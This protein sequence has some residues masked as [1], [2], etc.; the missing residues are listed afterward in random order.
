MG[1]VADQ[2]LQRVPALGQRHHH[3]GLPVAEMDIVVVGRDR[4]VRRAGL[5]V[6]Q[7]VVMPGPR[8]VDA[9]RRDPMPRRPIRTVKRSGTLKPS[10]G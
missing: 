7:Q 2:Q 10:I 5:G 9:G 4:L 1:V 3:F 6:D 8:M